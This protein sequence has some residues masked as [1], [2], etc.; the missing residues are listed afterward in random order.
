MFI[1]GASAFFQTVVNDPA[2]QAAATA[3]AS[4]SAVAA[5]HLT[6]AAAAVG[7]FAN[8]PAV[9]ERLSGAAAAVEEHFAKAAATMEHLA[10]V[11]VGAVTMHMVTDA[12]NVMKLLPGV[13]QEG[14]DKVCRFFLLPLDWRRDPAENYGARLRNLP[15]S[16]PALPSSLSAA[17]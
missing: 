6:N 12:A 11:G 8:D 9:Q 13:A 14:L 16:I 10:G 7:H 2:R 17:W 5:E 1:Q 4:A 3:L 15:R